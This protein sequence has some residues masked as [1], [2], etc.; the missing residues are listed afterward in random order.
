MRTR[1]GQNKP[2]YRGQG[3]LPQGIMSKFQSEE[4]VNTSLGKGEVWR[5]GE[6]RQKKRKETGVPGKR[7]VQKP[8]S[9]RARS[10]P[11]GSTEGLGAG[12][13]QGPGHAESCMP[14]EGIRCLFLEHGR[15]GIAM[16]HSESDMIRFASQRTAWGDMG[17]DSGEA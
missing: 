10:T 5:W 8:C 4:R 7:Y 9:R 3:G 11:E 14:R 6:K 1:Y 2:L 17:M 12:S 13:T 16:L 15:E